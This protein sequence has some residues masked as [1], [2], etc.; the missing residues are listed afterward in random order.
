MPE[1][2]NLSLFPQKAPPASKTLFEDQAEAVEAVFDYFFEKDGAPI[3]VVPTAGGKS[4]I[5]AEFMRQANERFPGTRFIVLS[6]VSLLLT[7]NADELMG[8][9]PDAS[10]TFYS[11]SLNQK[12]LSGDIVFAG[13]QSIYKRAYDFRHAPDIIIVDECFT[14]DTLIAT[15]DGEQRID[16]I[17]KGDTVLNAYGHG[18]VSGIKCSLPTHL[19]KLELSN[20]KSI[21]CTPDH[22][23]FTDQ[24]WRKAGELGIGQSLFSQQ[25]LSLLWETLYPMDEEGGERKNNIGCSRGDM[26]KNNVLLNILREEAQESYERQCHP[27]ENAGHSTKN[28]TCADKAWRERATVT[29]SPIGFITRAWRR[30]ARRNCNQNKCWSFERSLSELLQGGYWKRS[31]KNSDRNRWGLSF[32]RRKEG[33][34][35]E[36]NIPL[37][38]VRVESISYLERESLEP[39]FNLRVTGHPSYFANGVLVHNCHTISPDSG[40]MYRKFFDDMR[41]INPMIKIV[42]FTATPFRAGYGM[43]HKGKNALFT[44]IA[45]EIS[46]AELINRGRLCPV[47]TPD[48]GIKTKMDTSGVKMNGG[49]FVQSQLAKKVDKENV[50][51][52]CID[53]VIE[54]GA[55]RKKW[56]VFTVDIAHCE[57]VF[58]E[59]KSRGIDCEMVHSKMDVA[60]N[61]RAIDR[62]KNGN[63][64]CLVNVAMLTVGANFPAIDMGVF[65]RPTKS[66]VLYVQMTGRIMRLSPGKENALLLDFAGVI[67][68]L[69]PVDAVR[70]KEPGAGGGEAPVKSC[71]GSFAN[72]EKCGATLYASTMKCPHCGHDFPENPIALN[73]TPSD[74]AVL[75]S[76]LK[77][78][79]VK[80]S[81]V[82]YFRHKKEG[83]PD[84]MRVDYL[85]GFET[86][87]EWLHLEHF[88]YAREKSCQWWR[89]R[90]STTPPNTV[91]EALQR[92]PAELR[93]PLY[94]HVKKIGKYHEIVK[95]DFTEPE[96]SD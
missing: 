82:A 28:K 32:F 67:D 25:K 89:G 49:D 61:S 16:S 19:I 58:E 21:K 38:D 60:Q 22:P 24:G 42:G 5:I 31:V 54:H 29:A 76:Q 1:S 64:R 48:G 84:T 47:I 35:Q 96:D 59:I 46:I 71:P 55:D 88:G 70:V 6:H 7:Q 23:I 20:G 93:I 72:G 52:A 9:W 77:A 41:V 15:P 69:G 91:T 30:L 12:D 79:V 36:K 73:G 63:A 8:Q 90:S 45:Y 10:I 50:T 86:Y 44:D 2:H 27:N 56:I 37:G 11:D 65:M 92:A 33:A 26:E 51:K 18:T 57:H 40:S 39:V 4:L 85:C 80:V 78:K 68:E 83:K 14:G 43:L 74:A 87:R 62:F 53:E 95:A 94:I 3:L 17:K 81:R 66:P 75:S 34:G 13:I